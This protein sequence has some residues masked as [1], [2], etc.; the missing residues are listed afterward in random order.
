M[1]DIEY[2]PE[3]Q[4]PEPID[5]AMSLDPEPRFVRGVEPSTWSDHYEANMGRI[6]DIV[7]EWLKYDV[8]DVCTALMSAD[9][10]DRDGRICDEAPKCL[11]PILR[12][13]IEIVEDDA[14]KHGVQ[15]RD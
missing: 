11:H 15:L 3:L 14:K 13:L 7:C 5:Y 6:D 10:I 12:R 8:T 1:N 9:L 2:P 4:L